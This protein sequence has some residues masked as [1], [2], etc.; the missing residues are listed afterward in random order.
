M[1]FDTIGN[2]QPTMADIF[3]SSHEAISLFATRSYIYASRT[4][5][6]AP[7]AILVIMPH[8]VGRTTPVAFPNNP[9]SLLVCAISPTNLVPL[10]K[11]LS[12]SCHMSVSA[13]CMVA[14]LILSASFVAHNA[15]VAFAIPPVT[16]LKINFGNHVALSKAQPTAFF[17]HQATVLDHSCFTFISS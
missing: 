4:P 9:P 1:I 8:S 16:H 6:I 17:I 12:L 3:T 7:D 14:H 10:Y 13:I 15:S 11:R 2:A 5:H